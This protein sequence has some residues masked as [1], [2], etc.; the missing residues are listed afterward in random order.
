MHG[1]MIRL[2]HKKLSLR[3]RKNW[4]CT[5]LTLRMHTNKICVHA[6]LL[7]CGLPSESTAR[8]DTGLHMDLISKT[9]LF[10]VTRRIRTKPEKI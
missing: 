5:F 8:Q 3:L 4:S 1:R 10:T 6:L 9:L 7:P 2:K